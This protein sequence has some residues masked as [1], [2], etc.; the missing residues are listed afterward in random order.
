VLGVDF[1]DAEYGFKEEDKSL[2]KRDNEKLLRKLT[3]SCKDADFG[4]MAEAV[5]SLTIPAI[6]VVRPFKAYG[7]RLGKN[8][9]SLH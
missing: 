3:E 5:D 2:V 7:G 6:K 8:N 9:H 4:T 1:D